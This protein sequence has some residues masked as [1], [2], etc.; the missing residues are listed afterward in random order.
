M[1][2]GRS[3]TEVVFLQLVTAYEENR[4]IRKVRLKIS[5]VKW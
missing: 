1:K 5:A 4:R 3:N 2:K